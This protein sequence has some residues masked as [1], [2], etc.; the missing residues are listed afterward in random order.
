MLICSASA[1][2]VAD[3][4]CCLFFVVACLSL[5]TFG[6]LTLVY[7]LGSCFACFAPSPL[8]CVLVLVLCWRLLC[9]HNAG[10]SAQVHMLAF[11]CL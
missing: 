1:D 8:S 2:A 5:P 4:C 7:L 11:A 3:V 9:R 10:S 6:L